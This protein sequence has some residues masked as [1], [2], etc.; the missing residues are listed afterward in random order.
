MYLNKIRF[1][2]V[3]A[4][5]KDVTLKNGKKNEEVGASIARPIPE[6]I[7]EHNYSDSRKQPYPIGK[8]DKNIINNIKKTN[9][10]IVL[11]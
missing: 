9:K 2:I 7:E 5:H 11:I 3:A 6:S 1:Q 10:A 8:N 4:I